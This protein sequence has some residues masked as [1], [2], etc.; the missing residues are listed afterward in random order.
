MTLAHGRP[1]RLLE[2]GCGTGTLLRSLGGTAGL[3]LVGSEAYLRGLRSAIRNAVG[4]DFIQVDALRIPFLS[5]FDIVGAFDVIEHVDDDEAVLRGIFRALRPGGHLLL[6]V[7]QHR[8]LWSRLDELV[9]HKRR[10]G[11]RDLV[12]KTRS[13]GFEI[14]YVTSFVFALFPLLLASRLLD[15]VPRSV[16]ETAEFDKRVRFSPFVN[17]VFDA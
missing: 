12:D 13:A 7:P 14:G 8:F 15:R 4:V 11:R 6:T 1:T 2:I 17:R 10:Y 3:E 9:H 16:D 5:E